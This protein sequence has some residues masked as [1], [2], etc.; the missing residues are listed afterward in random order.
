MSALLIIVVTV[1]MIIIFCQKCSIRVREYYFI[2][3]A[4]DKKTKNVDQVS[5][6]KLAKRP[7][8]KIFI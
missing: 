2:F 6:F 1:C 5:V 4:K 3:L 8:K 7:K